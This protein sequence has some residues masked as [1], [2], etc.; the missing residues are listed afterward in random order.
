VGS[1]VEELLRFDSP[2]Q[3]TVL[4]ANLFQRLP[5]LELTC[6]TGEVRWR[7]NP[8]LRGLESLPVRA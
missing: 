5:K 4:F 2:V 8:I 6:G 1:A 3:A 7:P